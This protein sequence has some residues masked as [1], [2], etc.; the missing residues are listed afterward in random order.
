MADTLPSQ[1]KASSSISTS[2]PYSIAYSC[3]LCFFSFVFFFLCQSPPPS[4]PHY[5]S[6]TNK[7]CNYPGQNQMLPF[8]LFFLT[9]SWPSL[10]DVFLGNEMK[11]AN[12]GKTPSSSRQLI[13]IKHLITHPLTKTVP[14]FLV[15]F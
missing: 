4:S 15:L 13:R 14:F 9:F 10:V 7:G 5:T 11:A 1:E 6:E 3:F 2:Y 8:H 12:F